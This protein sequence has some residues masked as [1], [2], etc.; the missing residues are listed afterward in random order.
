MYTTTKRGART[1]P[2][3]GTRPRPPFGA[4]TVISDYTL[5][6]LRACRDGGPP[7]VDLASLLEGCHR[8]G[9]VE[10]QPAES[11]RCRPPLWVGHGEAERR[12]FFAGKAPEA[13]N[14]DYPFPASYLAVLPGARLVG[15]G[16]IIVAGDH[17]VITDS[18]SGDHILQIDGRFQHRTLQ[19]EA[20]GRRQ[21]LPFALA[22]RT[23]LPQSISAT[24]VLPTHYWHFNYHH[25]LIECLPRLR[26]A[27]EAPEL[28]GCQ[29]IIPANLAPFQRESLDLL[30]LPE[31]RR[32]PFDESDWRFETLV[33]PSIGSFS[34]PELRWVRERLVGGLAASDSGHVPAASRAARASTPSSAA[35][36]PTPSQSA[37]PAP[38]RLY[39]SRADAAT[40]RLVNEAELVAALE[41]LGFEVLT[42]TGM[43]LAEQIRR[44]AQA[45]LIV[46]PHGS[47]LTNILFAPRRATLIELMPGDQVNHCFWLLAN[48]LGLRYTF[49]A[50]PVVSAQRDFAIAPE[51]LRAAVVG[52]GGSLR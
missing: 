32:L 29:V 9:I 50:G 36:A 42:L 51:K 33:F 25:W 44:L 28:A 41:P 26:C 16:W 18:Y 30:G 47:G 4:G 19:V 20:D 46:G 45:E 15:R 1:G 49:L 38:T 12:F 13:F 8:D 17:H 40:R 23:S 27:L 39:I 3:A 31:A 52:M 22:R 5:H 43:P 24:V 48:G 6:P 14:L 7:A 35:G 10:T 37:T 21:S 11:L 2:P 34:P